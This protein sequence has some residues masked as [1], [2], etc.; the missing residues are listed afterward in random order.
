MPDENQHKMTTMR[1]SEATLSRLRKHGGFGD[2]Y[3]L[4]INKLLDKIE[5]KQDQGEKDEQGTQRS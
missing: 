1:V 2:T 5:G 3:D 4:I